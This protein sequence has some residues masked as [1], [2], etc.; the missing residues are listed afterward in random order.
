[1]NPSCAEIR[2]RLDGFVGGE[3]DAASAS[4]VAVHLRD[5]AACRREATGLQQVVHRLLGLRDAGHPEVD[6]STFAAM[7]AATMHRIEV[8][9]DRTTTATPWVRRVLP[10]AAA[11]GLFVAGW[12]MT[13]EPSPPSVFVRPPIGSPVALD[14]A[15]VGPA[16]FVVPMRQLGDESL[17][18]ASDGFGAGLMGRWRLRT[19]EGLDTDPWHSGREPAVVP[20]RGTD[21]PRR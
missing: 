9:V 11:A 10:I 5:C 17:G 13:R 20:V 21:D 15:G 4:V 3:L 7:H 12:W 1:M 6:D 8:E 18:P 19:L 16:T 14:R 2:T